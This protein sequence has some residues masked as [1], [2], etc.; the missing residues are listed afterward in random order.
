MKG[1]NNLTVKSLAVISSV[2][3]RDSSWLALSQARA[4]RRLEH[5]DLTAGEVLPMKKSPWRIIRRG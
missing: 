2:L 5:S 4:G 1:T 3:Y